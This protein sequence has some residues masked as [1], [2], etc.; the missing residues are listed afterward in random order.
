MATSDSLSEQL[1]SLFRALVEADEIT[2]GV[3]VCGRTYESQQSAARG[4]LNVGGR[5]VQLSDRFLVASLTKPMV[6]SACLLLAA[7][8]QLTLA[9]RVVHWLPE[10]SGGVRRPITIRHLLTHT[11][12]LPE[13]WPDNIALREEHAPLS[14][15]VV[16]GCHIEPVFRV[17]VKAEYSSV[18]YSLLG[19][20]LERVDGRPLPQLMHEELFRPLGMTQTS[21][22][23]PEGDAGDDIVEIRLPEEQQNSNWGWNS[24]YWQQLGA[25]WGGVISTAE[26]VARFLQSFA[27]W[28]DDGL[29]S[30]SLRQAAWTNQLP[31]MGV[32]SSS[33]H[34]RGWGLGWRLNWPGH[35]A[36]LCE[37][38][39]ADTVGHYGATGSVMWVS[40]NRYAVALTSEPALTRPRT[41]QRI[42]NVIASA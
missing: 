42:S 25:P 1:D 22:G 21:L 15:F 33:S 20:V 34:R 24:R 18:G 36:S 7:R 10:F 8:G 14:R 6:A 12:G 28:T 35:A 23:L 4:L 27:G 39:P 32:E 40:E 9:D 38:L 2:A 37:L 16:S 29:F 11:S 5:D 19:A 31:E 41:L 13:V 17:G 3:V 26:D 30:E